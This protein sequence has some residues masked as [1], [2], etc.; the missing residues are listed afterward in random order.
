MVNWTS[1]I[2]SLSVTQTS[3]KLLISSRPRARNTKKVLIRSRIKSILSR[4]QLSMLDN[5][6]SIWKVRIWGSLKEPET[7][8]GKRFLYSTTN[9][10]DAKKIAFISS[11]KWKTY[12][13]RLKFSQTKTN[14]SSSL[15]R[16]N[17]KSSKE[18][19]VFPLSRNKKRW[20]SRCRHSLR[21]CWKQWQKSRIPP[22]ST[23]KTKKWTQNESQKKSRFLITKLPHFK[24][25]SISSQTN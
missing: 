14:P 7:T 15:K 24:I 20:Q 4:G 9:Y 19:K 17:A 6:W 1:L 10:K 8:K 12:W 16:C 21:K 5:F 11:V 13:I 23:R 25:K 2:L 18:F 3:L 22:S